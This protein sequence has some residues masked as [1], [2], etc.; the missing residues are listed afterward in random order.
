MTTPASGPAIS[1][2]LSRTYPAPRERVFNAWTDPDQLKRWWAAQEGFTTPIAEV[3]LR[4]GG[5]YRLGMQP[6]DQDVIYVVSG[7]YREVTPP[8]RLVFTWA[9]EPPLDSNS[10]R[11]AEERPPEMDSMV[12]SKETLVTVEFRD[13]G[14]STEVMLTHAYFSDEPTRDEHSHGWAGVMARLAQIIEAGQV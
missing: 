3:D 4:V 6:P 7:T 1:L 10:M 13:L 5:R 2:S 12:E 9:W 8:Q 14:G 11:P